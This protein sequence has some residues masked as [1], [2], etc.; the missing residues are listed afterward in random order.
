MSTQNITVK[1]I[2]ASMIINLRF[3]NNLGY[4]NIMKNNEYND[5][6]GGGGGGGGAVN[7]IE[8]VI[9]RKYLSNLKIFTCF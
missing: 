2:E 9:Y 8:S 5:L 1:L 3:D 7:K 4:F 6:R